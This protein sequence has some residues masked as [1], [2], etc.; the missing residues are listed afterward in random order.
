[1]HV[2]WF[3]CCCCCFSSALTFPGNLDILITCVHA[4][5]RS[6]PHI[7]APPRTH[8]ILW[9][10][11]QIPAAS[12]LSCTIL[13][14]LL[15]FSGLGDKLSFSHMWDL[16]GPLFGSPDTPHSGAGMQQLV[17]YL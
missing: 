5:L 15:H 14:K 6:L 2:G 3:F 4:Q 1:M 8:L 13:G 16:Q 17:D 9:D 7:L 10:Q 12:L 11:V